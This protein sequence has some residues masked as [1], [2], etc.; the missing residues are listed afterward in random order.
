MVTDA[1]HIIILTLLINIPKYVVILSGDHI[2]KMDYSK[3]LD[4]HKKNNADAIAVLKVP[5]NEASRFGIMN[6]NEDDSIYQ[7]EKNQQIKE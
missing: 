2:Y 4:F 1:A 5:L 7:F 3:M 6:V